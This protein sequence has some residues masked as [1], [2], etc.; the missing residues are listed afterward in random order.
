M[1]TNTYR[2]EDY[3]DYDALSQVEFEIGPDGRS[4]PDADSEALVGEE[5]NFIVPKLGDVAL[6]A[7]E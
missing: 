2:A 6:K 1:E 3:S 4:Y 5:I 7:G